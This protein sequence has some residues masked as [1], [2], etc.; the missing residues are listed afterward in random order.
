[1]FRRARRIRLFGEETTARFALVAPREQARKKTRTRALGK[2][3]LRMKGILAFRN[4]PERFVSQGVYILLEGRHQRAWKE[5]EARL[6]RLYLHRPR[7]AAGGASR[8]L[9]APRRGRLGWAPCD[10]DAVGS[11]R[12]CRPLLTLLGFY[13]V[14]PKL[15]WI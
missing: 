15:S 13:R 3:I 4:D 10:A 5:D 12:N 9:R 2:A 8:R 6:S 11:S 7:P 1:M 14:L